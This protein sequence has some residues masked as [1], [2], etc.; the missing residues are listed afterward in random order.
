MNPLRAQ[1]CN[2]GNCHTLLQLLAYASKVTSYLHPGIAIADTVAK[3]DFRRW[4]AGKR[5][6][7][8]QKSPTKDKSVGCPLVDGKSVG[9]AEHFP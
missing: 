4:T 3:D 1:C 2:F 5:Y 6:I 8:Q 7:P 9:V